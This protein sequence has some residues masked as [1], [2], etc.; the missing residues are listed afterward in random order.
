MP[1]LSTNFDDPEAITLDA[2]DGVLYVVGDVQGRVRKVGE[3]E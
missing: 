3:N 1:A 2:D